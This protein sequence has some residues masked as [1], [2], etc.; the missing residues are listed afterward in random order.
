MSATHSKGGSSIPRYA[1][2]G[3][4]RDCR[5]S[6]HQGSGAVFLPAMRAWNRAVPR[7]IYAGK[8]RA[9]EPLSAAGERPMSSLILA[10]FFFAALHLGVGGHTLR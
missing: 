7:G 5:A 1:F 10:A 9:G 3:V 4:D 8:A 6:G 2:D